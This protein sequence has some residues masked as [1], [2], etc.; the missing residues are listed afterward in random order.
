MTNPGGSQSTRL[1]IGAVAALIALIGGL[2]VTMS[3]TG[4]DDEVATDPGGDQVIAVGGPETFLEPAQSIGVDAF[5]VGTQ[6]MVDIAPVYLPVANPTSPDPQ[7]EKS[8]DAG[9]Q[10]EAVSGAEPGLYGGTKD[11]S[12]CN[13]LRLVE[14]LESNPDKASA[15]SA[16]HGIDPAEIRS[17]VNTLTPV[18]LLKDTRVTNHGFRDGRAP[19]L[20]CWSMTKACPV[21]V[22]HA[23]TRWPNPSRSHRLC[24]RAVSGLASPRIECKWCRPQQRHSSSFSKTWKVVSCLLARPAQPVAPTSSPHLR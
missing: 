22:A 9:S 10:V 7:N 23:A 2:L 8:D 18:V 24:T 3:L 17:F 5:F 13:R 1:V 11:N 6:E 20:P 12:R 19:A 21:C 15:W 14:F 16:I 4:G